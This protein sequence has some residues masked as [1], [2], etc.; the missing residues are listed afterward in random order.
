MGRG[1]SGSGVL[2]EKGREWGGVGVGVGC[3][4]KRGESGEGWGA[5]WGLPVCSQIWPRVCICAHVHHCAV[6]C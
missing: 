3:C 5:V 4:V 6:S 1:G 2:C